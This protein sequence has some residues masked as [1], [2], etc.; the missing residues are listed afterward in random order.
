V[1]TSGA[2]PASLV[3]SWSHSHEEDDEGVQVFRPVDYDFPPS[4][5]RESFTLRPDGTAVAGLPGPD[6]RGISTDE[7]T[8]QLQGD[9]LHIRCPGWAATYEVV[10]AASQRLELRPVHQL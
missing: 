9:V 3:G 7:G 1:A 5:G 2:D 10:G 4:R 8:W 6:D